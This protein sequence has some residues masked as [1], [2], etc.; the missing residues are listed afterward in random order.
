MRFLAHGKR[1]R[2][3]RL[4]PF[5]WSAARRFERALAGEYELTV[6]RLLRR[7]DAGRLDAAIAIAELPERI[8]GFGPVKHRGVQA[9]HELE[10]ALLASYE[11]GGPVPALLTRA[12]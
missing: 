5:G 7:L 4:D 3:T 2:G 9:A 8:R 6:D 11:S 12:A 1:L 10:A